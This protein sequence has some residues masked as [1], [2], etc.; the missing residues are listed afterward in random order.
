MVSGRRARHYSTRDRQL[1]RPKFVAHR[2]ATL[3]VWVIVSGIAETALADEEEFAGKF[4]DDATLK[5][6]FG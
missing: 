1:K 5:N 3:T 4:R 2:G 6:A